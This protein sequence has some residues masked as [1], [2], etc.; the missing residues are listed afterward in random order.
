MT[1]VVLKKALGSILSPTSPEFVLF[2]DAA[3]EKSGADG[4]PIPPHVVIRLTDMDDYETRT[5][6]VE[7]NLYEA[8]ADLYISGYSPMAVDDVRKLILAH[9]NEPLGNG[10]I[11]Y[12]MFSDYETITNLA[13]KP[14][15]FES[16]LELKYRFKE[17]RP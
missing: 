1:A 10:A 13:K 3:P 11:D 9:E 8:Y 7:E 12:Y 2:T 4:P 15:T 6:S 17:D 5:S 14:K 16:I